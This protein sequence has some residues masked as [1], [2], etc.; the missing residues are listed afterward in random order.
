MNRSL[1]HSPYEETV[2]RD[3]QLTRLWPCL[4][5]RTCDV[6]MPHK[7]HLVV[8]RLPRFPPRQQAGLTPLP[9]FP[10]R[11]QA[12]FIPL[13]PV[14]FIS[15]EA[16]GLLVTRSSS[17]R[18]IGWEKGPEV[19]RKRLCLSCPN[20]HLT[21][22]HKHQSII[23]FGPL[24]GYQAAFMTCSILYEIITGRDLWTRC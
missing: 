9:R 17:P 6:Q 21:D 14:T 23:L 4:D 15:P 8:A 2:C 20:N 7:S 5:L 19:Q 24:E 22:V 13:P 11:Q 18:T 10:P 16:S 3:K 12:E 1:L